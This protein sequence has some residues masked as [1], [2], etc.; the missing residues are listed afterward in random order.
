MSIATTSKIVKSCYTVLTNTPLSNAFSG[1]LY[2]MIF[3]LPDWFVKWSKSKI[4]K[5]YGCSFLYFETENGVPKLSEKYSHQFITVHS[6]IVRD[7]SITLHT[8]YSDIPDNST[9]VA[10]GPEGTVGKNDVNAI[11]MGDGLDYLMTANNF[12][13][14][15]IYDLSNNDAQ[16]IKLWFLDSSGEKVCLRGSFT[17]ANEVFLGEVY[18]AAIRLECELAIAE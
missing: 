8:Y 1:G 10:V 6:N 4:I 2:A 11:T 18:Q 5:V 9:I 16:F 3:P 7:D 15:K 17:G 13:N 14:P 12:Y